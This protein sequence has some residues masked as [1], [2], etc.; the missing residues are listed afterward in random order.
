MRNRR[1]LLFFLGAAL[2]VAATPSTPLAQKLSDEVGALVERNLSGLVS[3]YKTLHAAPE[4]SG[5]EERTSAFVSTRLRSYG[6]EITERVGR[7]ENSKLTGYGVV[8]VMRNGPGPTVLVRTDLDALPVEE[9]TG[10]PYASKVRTKDDAGNDVPVMHACGHDIHITTL[11]GTAQ[12]LAQLK[13]RWHGTLILIGQPAE[14]TI[15]GAKAMLADGLYERFPRPEFVLALHDVPYL[16]AGKVGF[17]PG[18]A[19]S[20]ATSV[21]I[22][23]RGVGGHGASPQST[24]DPIVM[25]AEL[26]LILQTIVSR[27]NSPFDPAVVTVGSIHGGTKHNIIPDD[28]HLQLTVRAYREEVRQRILASIARMAKSISE[29]GGVPDSLSPI[30]KVSETEHVP[31]T[32]NDPDLTRRLEGAVGQALGR[33]NV[34]EVP[35]IMASEDF[36]LFGLGQKIPICMF[37]LGAADPAQLE[38]SRHGGPP[39]PSLH[40]SLWAPLPEPSIRTGVRA[41]CAAVLEIMK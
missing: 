39:M 20:S 21:D 10:L 23:M 41:M 31:A 13:A 6:Y 14:E 17:A 37:T 19:L 36:G 24:K 29:G 11:L 27:E 33:A 35:P 38:A 16:E 7:Y 5:H 4:L 3:T 9:K 28:V 34:S 40:S 12:A 25:A 26:V 32:Y 22:T 2:L 30:V 15:G 8:A 1:G 18:Y